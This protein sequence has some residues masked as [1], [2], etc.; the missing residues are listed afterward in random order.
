MQ[1]MGL[2]ALGLLDLMEAQRTNPLGQYGSL[3]QVQREWK[4]E[5]YN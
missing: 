3:V 1:T 2:R 4:R 5:N